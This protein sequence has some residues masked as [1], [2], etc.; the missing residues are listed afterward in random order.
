MER[1][2]YKDRRAIQYQKSYQGF[3][4]T[5]PAKYYHV[6]FYEE[7]GKFFELLTGRFLG[8]RKQLGQYDYVFSEDLGYAIPLSG[9]SIERYAAYI[10]AEEFAALAKTYMAD[11]DKILRPLNNRFEQ[12]RA[13]YRHRLEKE[14]AQRAAEAQK[15]RDDQQN[16]DW[17]SQLLDGRK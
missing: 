4:V 11:K 13:D 2:Y 5:T 15:K 17:L 3:F 1:K 6:L 9:Y 7:G 14:Q 8:V 16:V 12:W 10:T